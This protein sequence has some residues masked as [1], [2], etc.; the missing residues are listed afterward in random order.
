MLAKS[1]FNDLT[2]EVVFSG[3]AKK[4]LS[5]VFLTLAA[6]LS[7][8]SYTGTVVAALWRLVHYENTKQA[9]TVFTFK[10]HNITPN[11]SSNSDALY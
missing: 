8:L 5:L 11:F 9:I 1:I 4:V 3:G 6:A 2:S 10:R 7:F